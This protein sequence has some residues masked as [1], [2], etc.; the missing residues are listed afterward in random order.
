MPSALPTRL[1]CALPLLALVA[2]SAWG[3]NNND[4]P[5]EN[6]VEEIFVLSDPSVGA[7]HGSVPPAVFSGDTF[8]KVYPREILHCADGTLTAQAMWETIIDTDWTTPP[9][10][11]DRQIV[12]AYAC[13]GTDLD[14]DLA[15]DCLPVCARVPQWLATGGYDASAAS[16]LIVLGNPGVPNPCLVSPP[17]CTSAGI[18]PVSGF[19]GYTANWIGFEQNLPCPANLASYAPAEATPGYDG[20]V[21]YVFFVPGGMVYSNPAAPGTCGFGDYVFQVDYSTNE[22]QGDCCGQGFSPYGGYTTAASGTWSPFLDALD[23]TPATHLSFDQAVVNVIG[24]TGL[25]PESG[26]ALGGALNGLCLD[27]S[28]G[29]ASLSIEVRDY[30]ALLLP[31]NVALVAFSAAG[32]IPAPGLD[33]L[34]GKLLIQPDGLLLASLKTGTVSFAAGS[35]L[36]GEGVFRAGSV[37]VPALGLPPGATLPLL[38]QGFVLDVSNPGAITAHGTNAWQVTLR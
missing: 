2:S 16:P 28:G 27:T 4:V 18:C 23:R 3:Q 19:L 22:T 26:A 12:P 21:A 13:G 34:G 29:S 33:V 9:D 7:P 15:P 17:L 38:A 14:G 24:D 31:G 37:P 36:V 20:D 25:G 1:P 8:W 10:L 35:P 6:G 30:G 32:P 11:W 5:L